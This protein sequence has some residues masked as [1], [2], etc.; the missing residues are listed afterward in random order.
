[1]DDKKVYIQRLQDQ[2]DAWKKQVDEFRVRSAD[3]AVHSREEYQKQLDA[4]EAHGQAVKKQ[5]E[6][7]QQTAQQASEQAWNDM[8][9]KADQAWES[10]YD[11]TKKTLDRFK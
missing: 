3:M 4:L 9:V 11:V 10:L 5:M 8:K 7:A 1:M 6:A 2:L